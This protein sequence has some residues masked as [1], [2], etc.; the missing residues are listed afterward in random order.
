LLE[1]ETESMSFSKRACIGPSLAKTSFQYHVEAI[2]PQQNPPH[3]SPRIPVAKLE[4]YH[5]RSAGMQ[6]ML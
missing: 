6:A 3:H 1:E 4:K 2:S 5:E